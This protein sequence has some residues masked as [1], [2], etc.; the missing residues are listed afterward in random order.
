MAWYNDLHSTAWDESE[1]LRVGGV[2]WV[3][4][5]SG[6]RGGDGGSGQGWE[7]GGVSA[8][9]E[10]AVYETKKEMQNE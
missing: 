9:I 8:A 10:H 7:E 5:G 1:V 2:G 4:W 6:F 3:G